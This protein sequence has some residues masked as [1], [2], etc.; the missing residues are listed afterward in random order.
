MLGIDLYQNL[1]ERTQRVEASLAQEFKKAQRQTFIYTSMLAKN[2]VI[3]R[4]THFKLTGTLLEQLGPTLK[5]TGVDEIT[6]HDAKGLI[7]AQAHDRDRLNISDSNPLVQEANSGK[8][9]TVLH[10]KAGIWKMSTY[11][12]IFH[13]SDHEFVVGTVSVG[14]IL[15]DAFA[16]RLEQQ[17]GH[18]VIL[19]HGSKVL[20]SSL[21]GAAPQILAEELTS[22]RIRDQELELATVPVLNPN[23]QG[24]V[25]VALVDTFAERL[26]LAWVALSIPILLFVLFRERSRA[27]Q[28]EKLKAHAESLDQERK[29][30]SL[31]HAEVL[32]RRKTQIELEK[33]LE[34]ATEASRLKGEFLS[35]VS[36][37]LRTPL[38]A[39]MNIPR[40]LLQDFKEVSCWRCDE[41]QAAFVD[42]SDDHESKTHEPGAVHPCPDCDGKLHHTVQTTCDADFSEHKRFLLRIEKSG[43]HLLHIIDDVLSM[44]RLEAGADQL[45]ISDFPIS[46][47]AIELYDLLGRLA[48]E[49]NIKLVYPEESGDLIV[50]ADFRKIVQILVNLVGNAIKFTPAGGLVQIGTESDSANTAVTFFVTDNGPGIPAESQVTI[51][52]SFRQVD[53]SST[54]KH[55]GTGL[56]LSICKGLVELHEGVI[57]VES[58][59]G[60]G[61][62]FKFTIPQGLDSQ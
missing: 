20:G 43:A 56:G 42:S 52:E 21:G 31:L 32:R 19:V 38:N 34:K 30:A 10:E 51:F 55:P 36:H 29:A 14:Y 4:S 48:G 37:E 46:K 3:Q 28:K 7:L 13:K 5:Q 9:L 23:G 26:V 53:G 8:V 16:N 47:L 6:I 33:A 12:P 22:I 17:I 54:R 49:K 45:K 18:P 2:Q 58:T 25:A 59:L 15:S 41:C 11:H 57:G 35:T 61:S 50:R 44:S 39:I 1:M 27:I 40:G 24:I 62:T 60:E